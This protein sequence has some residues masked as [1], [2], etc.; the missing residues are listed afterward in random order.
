MGETPHDFQ[1]EIHRN[2]EISTELRELLNSR[3]TG[4][5]LGEISRLLAQLDLNKVEDIQNIT[6]TSMGKFIQIFTECAKQFMEKCTISLATITAVLIKV[7]HRKP[8][9]LR[10]RALIEPK[11]DV[12]DTGE[13]KNDPGWLNIPRIYMRELALVNSTQGDEY[14]DAMRSTKEE[15]ELRKNGQG[16]RPDPFPLPS[17]FP[18]PP[19]PHSHPDPSEG[20]SNWGSD[21]PTQPSSQTTQKSKKKSAK[22]NDKV[23]PAIHKNGPRIKPLVIASLF[24]NQSSLLNACFTAKFSENDMADFIEKAL[25]NRCRTSKSRL[26]VIRFVLDFLRLC[27]LPFPSG[28]VYGAVLRCGHFVL[29]RIYRWPGPFCTPYGPLRARCVFGGDGHRYAP[30]PSGGRKG[31]QGPKTVCKTRTASV[32]GIPIRIRK[33]AVNANNPEG[34]RVYCSIF[35]LLIMASLRFADTA[36]VSELWLAETAVCGRSINHKDKM[37]RRTPG[38]PRR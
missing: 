24:A 3:C 16:N 18:F 13:K 28:P 11:I 20:P 14:R 23:L 31:G 5:E 30:E 17:H 26:N 32:S 29:A 2:N 34:L 7:W 21:I 4:S 38:P 22:D 27:N 15:L 1:I 19:H 10:K 33:Q 37:G 8:S 9:R 25:S 6:N 12:A 35:V 36:D